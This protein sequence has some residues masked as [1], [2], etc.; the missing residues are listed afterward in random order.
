MVYGY[1]DVE[2]T[3]YFPNTISP[4]LTL[5]LNLSYND[6][7][8]TDQQALYIYVEQQ[9]A[10]SLEAGSRKTLVVIK[11]LN[12]S[13]LYLKNDTKYYTACT[14]CWNPIKD[15]ILTIRMYNTL[16]P[17]LTYYDAYGNQAP[18]KEDY[19]IAVDNVWLKYGIKYYQVPDPSLGFYSN[20][21]HFH[22]Y[23]N[24][25]MYLDSVEIY[26]GTSI[27]SDNTNITMGK[28][29]GNRTQAVTYFAGWSSQGKW[30][31]TKSPQC[32]E[33]NNRGDFVPSKFLCMAGG[34]AGEGMNRVIS[35]IMNNIIAFAL[36]VFIL[37]IIVVPV[38]LTVR[39]RQ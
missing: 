31:C 38:W 14:N 36:I 28:L 10:N 27:I 24:S 13:I 22:K 5:N 2:G 8:T 26:K 16:I 35:W 3:H 34:T 20:I 15:H 12:N 30:D 29:S 37:I 21:F 33:Y 4:I 18:H 17:T 7:G 23:Y 1:Y 9:R 6:S 11:I 32:C 25:T 19:D 39:R